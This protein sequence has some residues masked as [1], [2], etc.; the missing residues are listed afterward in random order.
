MKRLGMQQPTNP[1]MQV[2]DNLAALL[3]NFHKKTFGSPIFK[4]RQIKPL[5]K[6]NKVDKSSM[7]HRKVFKWTFEGNENYEEERVR[8]IK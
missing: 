4:L 3:S 7:G 6:K 1:P 5:Q 2:T 8:V